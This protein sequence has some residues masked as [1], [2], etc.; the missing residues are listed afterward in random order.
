[1][2]GSIDT[3]I[4]SY[5]GV[6]LSLITFNVLAVGLQVARKDALDLKKTS[7]LRLGAK[8][9]ILILVFSSHQCRA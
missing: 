1:M 3:T 8:W 6:R 2:T 9:E 7:F 5:Q 4:A